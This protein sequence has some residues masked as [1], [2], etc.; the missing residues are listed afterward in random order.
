MGG[1]SDEAEVREISSK[2]GLDGLIEKAG[3]WNKL[4]VNIAVTNPFITIFVCYI[5][6]LQK[7][8]H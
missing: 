6:Y 2:N 4:P 3:I 5:L 8:H 7:N 1:V